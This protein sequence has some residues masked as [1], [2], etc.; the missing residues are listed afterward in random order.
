MTTCFESFQTL[1]VEAHKVA[2]HLSKLNDHRSCGSRDITYLICHV[3]LQDHFIKRSCSSLYVTTLLGLVTIGIAVVKICF[4]SSR[5]LMWTHVQR[6]LWLYGWNLLIRSHQPA[7]FGNQRHAGSEYIMILACHVISHNHVIIW[8]F[9]L[10][11]RSH[12]R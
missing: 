8:S 7:K 1:C 9:D 11:D 6:V 10:T 2:H 4:D 5:G 12:S 3:T